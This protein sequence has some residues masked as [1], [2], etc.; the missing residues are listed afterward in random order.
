M[1]MRSN[2]MDVPIENAM[3]CWNRGGGVLVVEHP[4]RRH[5]S[6]GYTGSVGACFSGWKAKGEMGQKLQLMIDAWDIAAFD[7]VPIDA[8]HK[9]LLV[10]PE[11]R[12]M[13]A[14]D[15]LPREFRHERD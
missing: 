12:S 5:A 4:D 13:L 11:Y 1:T 10:I 2:A 14:D 3:I 15:C 9:A 6:D 8:V 7:G